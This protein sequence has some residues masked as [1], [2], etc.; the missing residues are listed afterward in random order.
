M[1]FLQFL[2]SL[3]TENNHFL[4]EAV[5]SGYEACFESYGISEKDF[6]FA[7]KLAKER[8][9][10]ITQDRQGTYTIALAGAYN[11]IHKVMRIP[12]GSYIGAFGIHI[13]KQHDTSFD[14][15]KVRR[16]HVDELRDKGKRVEYESLPEGVKEVFVNELIRIMPELRKEI[17]KAKYNSKAEAY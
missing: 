5:K 9:F 6:P 3:E 4:L 12:T 11:N 14:R 16:S 13:P 17:S 10:L 2:K 1:K 7:E 15:V 8:I